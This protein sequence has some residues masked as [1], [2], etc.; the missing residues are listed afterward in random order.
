VALV[1]A[2]YRTGLRAAD[3]GIG[4]VAPGRPIPWSADIVTGANLTDAW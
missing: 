3:V 4:V 2:E 1:S